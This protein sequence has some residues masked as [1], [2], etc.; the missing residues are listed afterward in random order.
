MIH[1]LIS[2]PLLPE[3]IAKE[4]SII[5][6]IARRNNI[7]IDVDKLIRKKRI[8]HS[9]NSTTS[10]PRNAPKMRWIRTPFLGCLSNKIARI[11]KAHDLRPAYYSFNRVRDLFP[12]SKDPIP[13]MEKSGV[14]KLECSDCPAIYIGQ[15]GRK[16]QDRVTEHEKA[17]LKRTPER[18]NFAA[19]LID[20]DQSFSKS[21]GTH[22][23]HSAGRGRRLTALEEVEIIKHHKRDAPLANKVIPDSRL[24]D[25]YYTVDGGVTR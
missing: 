16:L 6:S 22:L 14:Y 23:L 5:K 3:A 1:R 21:T 13:L 8:A 15:T 11:L 4:T 19:H 7:N 24:A 17:F 2:L 25:S 20:S 18:S 12:S 9:L 10:L